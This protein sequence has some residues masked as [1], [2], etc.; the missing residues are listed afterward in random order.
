[1]LSVVSNGLVLIGCIILLA[2]LAVVRK[3]TLQLPAGRSCKSWCAMSGL[4]ILFVVGYAVYMAIFWDK[5]ATILDLIVPGIF[6]FGACFVWFS[7]YIALQTTLDV[8]RISDLEH[9]TLTDPLTGVYNR[10]FMEQRFAEEI[11]KARRYCFQ[12]SILLFDLDHF[13]RVND[14][15]GHQ[16]G[17]RMLI[18]ICNLVNDQLR[19]SDILSRYGGEEFLVIAPNTGPAE[20]ALLAERLRTRIEANVFLKD[21]QELTAQGQPITTTISVGIASFNDDN[22]NQ[23]T[24]IANADRNLYQA[25][26]EGR[27]RVIGPQDPAKKAGIT[28]I[29]TRAG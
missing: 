2:S 19:D 21:Q 9:E 8:I 4:I 10:R 12:L 1:M 5:H 20:A 3:I 23:E 15:H 27:N 18:E 16:A 24:L 6:F 25:K 14:E 29:A 22:D 13:K 7:T 28:G 11:S 26:H 17:D